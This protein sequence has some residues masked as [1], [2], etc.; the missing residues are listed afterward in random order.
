MGRDF[1]RR[2]GGSGAIA[3]FADPWYRLGFVV[4]FA[5]E[6]RCVDG[7]VIE[8][9]RKAL[10]AGGAAMKLIAPRLGEIRLRRMVVGFESAATR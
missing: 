10:K 8:A 1:C 3:Y 2:G 5:V 9:V 6:T 4:R 7:A